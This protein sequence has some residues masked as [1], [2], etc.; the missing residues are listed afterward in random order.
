MET[1]FKSNLVERTRKSSFSENLICKK[2]VSAKPMV[3]HNL[4]IH[5]IAKLT[6]IE[7]AIFELAT[8]MFSLAEFDN[9]P[10]SPIFSP[11]LHSRCK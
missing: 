9:F 2:G 11:Y 5:K 1:T 4:A 3:Q 7:V 6:R 10:N 8:L